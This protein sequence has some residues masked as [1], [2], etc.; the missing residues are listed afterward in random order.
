LPL[1][2]LVYALG[3][4]EGERMVAADQGWEM[5]FYQSPLV[6]LVID[7]VLVLGGLAG[8]IGLVVEPGVPRRMQAAVAVLMCVGTFVVLPWR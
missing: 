4:L 3:R 6:F 8:L 1:A 7:T 5:A 2:G